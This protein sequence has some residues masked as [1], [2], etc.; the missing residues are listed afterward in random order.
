MDAADPTPEWSNDGVFSVILAIGSGPTA[1]EVF[2][3]AESIPHFTPVDVPP[4][5]RPGETAV[6]VRPPSH[7]L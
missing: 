5:T 7:V 2:A 3:L 4:H 1:F 6:V